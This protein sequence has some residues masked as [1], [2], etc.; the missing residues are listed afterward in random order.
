MK[1][2]LCLAVVLCCMLASPL[3]AHADGKED[4]L[5]G[6]KSVQSGALFDAT[7]FFSKAIDSGDLSP[8]DTA[9]TLA[10]RG[11]VWISLGNK[12]EAEKD[13]RQALKIDPE[14][15]AAK[16]GLSGLDS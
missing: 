15:K 5:E 13:F 16:Q 14:N 4:L 11:N 1:K 9:V 7:M 10:L 3:T 6:V 2:Y 8:H 12:S